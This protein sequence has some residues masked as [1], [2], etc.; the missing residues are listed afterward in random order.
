[1]PLPPVRLRNARGRSSVSCRVCV[2]ETR[3]ALTTSLSSWLRRLRRLC[4]GEG[5]ARF[6]P[7]AGREGRRRG[8]PSSLARDEQI[9]LGFGVSAVGERQ[10]GLPG[11]RNTCRS[12]PRCRPWRGTFGRIR[13]AVQGIGGARPPGAWLCS[14]RPSPRGVRGGPGTSARRL[15]QRRR[16]DGGTPRTDVESPRR[17]V[18]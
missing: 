8:P 5:S 17:P 12:Q 16:Q 4:A 10:G 3:C 14:R 6:P 11:R 13:G 18:P 15:G 7:N 9:A 2:I 1:M